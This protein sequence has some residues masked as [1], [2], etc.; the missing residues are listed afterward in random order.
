MKVVLQIGL[1][2]ITAALAVS[3]EWSAW[4]GRTTA[5]QLFGLAA[6]VLYAAAG[7]A[8]GVFLRRGLSHRN[9]VRC[10][11]RGG[12]SDVSR[13]GGPPLGRLGPLD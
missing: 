10:G 7:W 3:V 13:R 4:H 8:A 6:G 9:G 5:L 12:R 1:G 11:D 2:L